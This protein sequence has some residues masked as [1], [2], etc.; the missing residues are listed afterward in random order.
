MTTME[1][2]AKNYA[3]PEK[4]DIFENSL[5][6]GRP[7]NQNYSSINI[8]EYPTEVETDKSFKGNQFIKDEEDK[9][10]PDPVEELK[11]VKSDILNRITYETRDPQA[12]HSGDDSISSGPKTIKTI[13][14]KKG[15]PK[16]L[17][18]IINKS[19]Y[20]EEIKEVAISMLPFIPDAQAACIDLSEDAQSRILSKFENNTDMQ[21]FVCKHILSFDLPIYRL[22]NLSHI[23]DV[24]MNETDKQRI[25]YQVVIL[26]N[27]ANQCIK[28]GILQPFVEMIENTSIDNRIRVHVLSQLSKHWVANHRE[29]PLLTSIPDNNLELKRCAIEHLVMMDLYVIDKKS[30]LYPYLSSENNDYRLQAY[31]MKMLTKQMLDKRVNTIPVNVLNP[32]LENDNPIK[33]EAIGYITIWSCYLQKKSSD[34]EKMNQKLRR[35]KCLC[36]C[37]IPDVD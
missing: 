28:N 25:E 19:F 8:D 15:L 10:E 14:E 34:L 6:I 31:I 36:P 3:K 11:A 21:W 2:L 9:D 20:G 26:T 27:C 30:E 24:H 17:S 13:P 1:E 7:Y 29:E 23:I 5:I 37:L 22:G 16:V 35:I 18:N 32:L 33:S 12:T 4:K